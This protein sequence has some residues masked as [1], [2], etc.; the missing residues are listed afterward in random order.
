MLCD[1]LNRFCNWLE[2]RSP[3]VR[4]ALLDW[5]TGPI[6]FDG[7][8]V[9]VKFIEVADEYYHVN[10]TLAHNEPVNNTP[11]IGTERPSEQVSM[12]LHYGE[13]YTSPTEYSFPFYKSV[14]LAD[15][16][17]SFREFLRCELENHED[18]EFEPTGP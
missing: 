7:V 9:V 11:V 13:T 17:W 8:Y 12:T 3:T 14:P 16:Q 6:L 2:G 5:L 4:D 15:N 10:F 1:L 18:L